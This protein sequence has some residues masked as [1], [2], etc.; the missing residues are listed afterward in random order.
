MMKGYPA[1]IIWDLDG[2]LIDSVADLTRSLNTLLREHGCAGLEER[3]IRTMIG[4]GVAE[5][6]ER[7]FRAAG[8]VM[9]EPKLQSVIPRFAQIYAACATEKTC[10]YPAAESVLQHFADAGVRQGICTNKP[11]D[12]TKQILSEL[13]V[14][15]HFDVVVGG[16]TTAA[17]KPDPLPLR[18][19]FEALNVTPQDGM[20]I[21]DSGV[22]VAT[23]R[24]VNAPVGIV[25]YGYARAPVSTLGADVLIDSLSS[26]PSLIGVL[27]EAE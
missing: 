11:E 16:D 27:S 6:I 10:L 14:A 2:T 3:Q 23:A 12:V 7:G 15:R 19:C 20:M 22:D 17:N 25:T 24:A 21:G 8:A 9:R 13:L 26:L 5:L 4:D 1:A 18:I